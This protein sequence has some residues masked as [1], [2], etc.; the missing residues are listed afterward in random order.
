MR[1]NVVFNNKSK[2]KIRF[3]DMNVKSS[4]TERMLQDVTPFEWS[5]DV[6]SGDSKVDI[7]IKQEKKDV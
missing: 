1:N 7:K 5:Q 4:S 2:T 6:L 3:N